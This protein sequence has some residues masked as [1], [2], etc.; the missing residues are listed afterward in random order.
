MHT[1][2]S[3]FEGEKQYTVGKIRTFLSK[4]NY[5]YLLIIAEAQ[6]I[7]SIIILYKFNK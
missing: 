6:E 2:P 3:N 1:H 4:V 5:N 7:F